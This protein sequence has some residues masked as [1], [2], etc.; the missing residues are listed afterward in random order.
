MVSDQLFL[1]LKCLDSRCCIV[2]RIFPTQSEGLKSHKRNHVDGVKTLHCFQS[3]NAQLF[4]EWMVNSLL[5][6]SR[7]VVE[8]VL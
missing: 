8:G 3:S 2:R 6:L 4:R 1:A 7:K 5:E